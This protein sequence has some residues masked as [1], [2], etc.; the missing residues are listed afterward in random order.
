M[1]V[2]LTVE[3]KHGELCIGELTDIEDLVGGEKG[4]ADFCALLGVVRDIDTESQSA[5]DDR[6]LGAAEEIE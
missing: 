1:S 5:G 3:L 6:V 2:S 4:Q